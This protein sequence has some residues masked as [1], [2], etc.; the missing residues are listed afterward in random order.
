MSEK[1]YLQFIYDD[2]VIK[3]P[4]CQNNGYNCPL[5][6]F[7]EY[8]AHNIILDYDYVDKFCRAEVG[9]DYINMPKP[10]AKKTQKKQ[11]AL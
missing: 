2:E 4:S 5:D 3:F 10:K 8:A 9:V 11:T 1:F 7:I 6:D